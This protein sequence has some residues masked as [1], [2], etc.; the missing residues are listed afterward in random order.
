MKIKSLFKNISIKSCIIIVVGCIIQ[1]V[2]IYNIHSISGVTEG[3]VLGLLLLFEFWFSISPAITSLILNAICYLIGYKVLGKDFIFYSVLS[4]VSFSIFY[5]ILELFPPLYP[6]IANYPLIAAILGGIFI[7]VGAGLTVKYGAASS[8]DDAIAMTISKKFNIK[9]QTVYLFSDLFVMLLS[10][11]YIPFKRIIFSLLTVILSG[12][13]IG[14]IVNEKDDKNKTIIKSEDDNTKPLEI[15]AEN[16]QPQKNSDENTVS[17]NKNSKEENSISNNKNEENNKISIN[18]NEKQI[19]E[20][21]QSNE[22]K[23]TE[24]QDPIKPQPQTDLNENN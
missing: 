10:L 4:I 23:T 18:E 19:N 22:N 14:F 20:N 6:N 16:E 5:A 15:K 24:N 1:A 21:H 7:G 2:G 12:Q 8:G 11:T 9:I 17:T 13:I 3:G